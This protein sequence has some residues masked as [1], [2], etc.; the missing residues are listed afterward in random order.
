MAK[1]PSKTQKSQSKVEDL[2]TVTYTNDLDQA[3]E[4]EVL[5]KNSDIPVVI[6]E[7]PNEFN[8]SQNIAVMVPEDFIDEAHVIIESQ[9]AYDDFYDFT[10]EDENNNDTGFDG[11][12]F[13]ED[14]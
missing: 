6:K 14:F 2:V 3:K 4:Y 9:D 8:G 10:E 11:D 7:I 5:L 12:T 13:D 1:R